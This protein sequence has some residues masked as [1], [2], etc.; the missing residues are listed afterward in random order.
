MSDGLQGPLVIKDLRSPYAGKY[1]DE[2]V[3]NVSDWYHDEAPF[4]IAPYL[5]PAQNPNGAEPIPHSS[6]INK[7]QDTKLVVK[8]DTTYLVRIISMAAFA[9]IYVGFD[10]HEMTIVAIDGIYVE[11]RKVSMIFLAVAQ[12][13]DV[14]LTTK[15]SKD[16]NYAFFSNLDQANLVTIPSYLRSNATGYLVYDENQPLPPEAPLFG[17]YDVI[18]DLS[19]VRQN[20]QRLIS[21]KPDASIVLNIDFF[22]RDGRIGMPWCTW[23]YPLPDL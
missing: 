8:P 4:L 15:K 6:L 21:G 14:L 16:K 10:Q 17:R 2:L 3:V 19:L 13:Y 11:P 5:S 7:T 9:Q 20:G 23:C 22:Q 18:D 12:R 1:S